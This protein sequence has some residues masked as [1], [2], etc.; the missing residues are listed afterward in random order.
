M[1]ASVTVKI[2]NGTAILY[3][4]DGTRSRTICKD[5]VS[6]IV[7]GEEVEVT[8]TNGEVRVYSVRGFY[9]KTL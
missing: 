4:T 5:A 3:R 1:A 7:K 8:A 2:E 9:K 6:A